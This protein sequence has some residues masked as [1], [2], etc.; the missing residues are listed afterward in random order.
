M[1]VFAGL[2]RWLTA[3]APVAPAKSHPDLAPIDV[4]R[5]VAELD[6]VAEGARL[7]ALGVPAPDA[8]APS[9]PE[10]AALQRIEKSR[11]DYVDWAT[12]RLGVIDQG[13]AACDV[14]A[15]VNRA[16]QAD[17]EFVRQA[18]ALIAEREGV[19]RACA[20]AAQRRQAELAAFRARHSLAREA[21]VLEFWGRAWR[22]ALVL[23]LAVVEGVLNAGFFAQG[24]DSGLLG[25]AFYAMLLAL[26]NVGTAYAFGRWLVRHVN[27]R[28][29]AAR[30]F[31]VASLV[32]AIA[33]LVTVA[34]CIAHFRDALTAE[35]PDAS[36]VALDALVATP[37]VL[38]DLMSWGLFG[39][40]VFFGVVAL[41]D[42]YKSDDPYP[43]YS[44]VARRARQAVDDHVDEL[45][46][47]RED[48][49]E[50]KERA[51]R[52]LD[53][54]VRRAQ[55]TVVAGAGWLQDKRAA[56][57]RLHTALRDADHALAAVLAAFRTENEAHRGGAPRPAY[58][59]APVALAPLRLPDFRVEEAERRL[60]AQRAQVDALLAEVEAART[61]IQAAYARTFDGLKPLELHFPRDARPAPDPA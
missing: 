22:A 5:V 32:A 2:F 20:E 17:P 9:G 52:A 48:L 43:G 49:D 27:H 1:A 57:S 37:F 18:S 6:L 36:R 41:A 11:Q 21:E 26:L 28:D 14:T 8:T 31:G 4:A 3:S 30:L 50:L 56:E 23:F 35:R 16:A 58:F 39:L 45:D 44:A 59:D 34:L 13:L 55:A 12:L 40:S 19:L 46:A 38:H 60:A 10:T 53:E 24:L 15:E 7:G 29:V 33:A 47:L 54:S 42:G 51:L 25:G 61:R